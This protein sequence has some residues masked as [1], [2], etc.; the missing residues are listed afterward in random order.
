MADACV[1]EIQGL[2][3]ELASRGQWA[4]ARR[5]S[6]E[7]RASLFL[8]IRRIADRYTRLERARLTLVT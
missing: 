5:P 6:P 2:W 3:D 8:Q 7:R 4:H 1:W